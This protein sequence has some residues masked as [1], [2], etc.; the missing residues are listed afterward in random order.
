MSAWLSIF[1]GGY[2]GGLVMAIRHPIFPLM[3]YLVF[4]YMPPHLNWWGR[5]LP[6][7]RYS[8]LAA[9][10]VALSVF[11]T[12]TTVEPLEEEKNPAMPWLLL[13]GVNTIFVTAWALDSARSWLFTTGFLKL[14]LIYALIPAAVRTP[15]QFDMFGAVHVAGATYWGYKAWDDPQRSA[16]R[17][18]EVGGPDTQNDNLAAAH[19]LTV[20][21]FAALYLLTLKRKFPR[22]AAAVA[23]GFIANVFI[24]CNSR[25]ATLGLVSGGLSALFLAG[26]GRRTK[27]VGVGI[28][29]VVAVLLLADPEF[30]TRQQ[31][32]TN[33]QDNSAQSRLVMWR[34][35]AEMIRDRPLGAGGRAFHILSPRYIPEVL[36]VTDSDER[37]SHNTYVQLGTE[38]G[39]QGMV[40]WLGFVIVT[41][42]TLGHIRRRTPDNHWYFYRSLTIQVGLIGTLTSAFF[43]N[44]LYGESIYWICALA[45]AL[46]RMQ[47]TDLAGTSVAPLLERQPEML[48]PAHVLE[49]GE[50]RA[51]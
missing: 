28:A 42:Q 48:V 2:F 18:E 47:T 35:G 38:W 40:L 31:T 32:T 7:L 29:G 13:M 51:S 44:R 22:A 6:D 33:P 25:G 9:G 14:I 8:L 12:R 26:K 4:Y 10:V 30:I 41:L 23:S 37:S 49:P 16:G 15:M 20:M 45:F 43:S 11:L 39:V 36:A 24:L 19:L 17:L 21:P 3:A 34:A 1:V 5:F 46:H 27:M 50:V